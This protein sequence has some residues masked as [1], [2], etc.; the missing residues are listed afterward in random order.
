MGDDEER[1]AVIEFDSDRLEIIGNPSPER[2]VETAKQFHAKLEAMSFEERAAYEW[3][4]LQQRIK[5]EEKLFA[6]R[7][8]EEIAKVLDMRDDFHSRIRT[9]AR[10]PGSRPILLHV[11]RDRFGF[12]VSG[13]PEAIRRGSS[14][15][16]AQAAPEAS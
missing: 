7:S 12:P 11:E 16:R 13:G 10:K 1:P 3:E 2:M 14:Q 4:K 6:G 9:F 15:S 8:P 5:E